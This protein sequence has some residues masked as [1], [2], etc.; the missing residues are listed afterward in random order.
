[1]PDLLASSSLAPPTLLRPDDAAV[2]DLTCT[3]C[4]SVPFS[5]PV[6][7]PCDHVFCRPCMVS[8]LTQKSECPNDRKALQQ[9]DVKD[10]AGL[11]RR[12]WANVAVACPHTNRC[13]WTGTMGDYL[14]H[15]Q[16]DCR[17][18]ENARLANENARL[19]D[20]IA[21]MEL[22]VLQLLDVM[23]KTADDRR[24]SMT[25]QTLA[26]EV[27]ATNIESCADNIV[28]LNSEVSLLTETL[29]DLRLENARLLDENHVVKN[30]YVF[31]SR[32]VMSNSTRIQALNEQ[33]MQANTRNRELERTQRELEV[34]L[35]LRCDTS[36][37]Y[38]SSRVGELTLL[39]CANLEKMPE[40]MDA[41]RIY[42]CVKNIRNII[43]K[44]RRWGDETQRR[45]P[46]NV[47]MLLSVCLAS[48]GWFS[49]RLRE[50]I[51][52]WLHEINRNE[53]SREDNESS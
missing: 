3:L 10:M 27:S 1:M 21:E 33:I 18:V 29:S 50:N 32:A 8:S 15:A 6:V 47:R 22:K 2:Q 28:A 7:T 16:K 52:G 26:L 36:Y 31:E 49:E 42:R 51:R 45:L 38:T 11:M 30:K 20:F 5:D 4:L 35:G 53:S 23:K 37:G 46:L 44:H 48:Q 19:S 40:G 12:V 17:A 9:T 34:Q 13:D 25:E 41:H 43:P 24:K 14:R 39:I